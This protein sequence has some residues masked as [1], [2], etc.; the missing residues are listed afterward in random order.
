MNA[1]LPQN[2]A[3]KDA[4]SQ[5]PRTECLQG[6]L[7]KAITANTWEVVWTVGNIEVASKH[8]ASWLLNP[9]NCTV[10]GAVPAIPAL[11]I[12]GNGAAEPQ[13]ADGPD[14][15]VHQHEDST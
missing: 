2:S 3:L 7:V 15:P 5:R 11:Q 4:C 13:C 10:V 6:H 8:Q 12:N 1:K 14:D 9:H